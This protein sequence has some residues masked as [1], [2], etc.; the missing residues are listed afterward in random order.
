MIFFVLE[1]EPDSFES[2]FLVKKKIFYF[3]VQFFLNYLLLE[4]RYTVKI[5][6]RRI[7]VLYFLGPDPNNILGLFY[8][9]FWIRYNNFFKIRNKVQ[10]VDFLSDVRGRSFCVEP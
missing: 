2:V 10:I 8:W 5:Q 4:C 9:I 6:K 3:P 1:P 7:F